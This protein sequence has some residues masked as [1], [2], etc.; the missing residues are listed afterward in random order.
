MSHTKSGMKRWQV[1]VFALSPPHVAGT[2][3]LPGAGV[4]VGN[5]MAF[6]VEFPVM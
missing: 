3:V 5:V 6:E 2:E 1:E 4:P